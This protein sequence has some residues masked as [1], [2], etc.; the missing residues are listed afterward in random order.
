MIFSLPQR[1]LEIKWA[2]GGYAALKGENRH[3]LTAKRNRDLAIKHKKIMGE[4]PFSL[5][6]VK[7]A[8]FGRTLGAQYQGYKVTKYLRA[9]PQKRNS[10]AFSTPRVKAS[11]FKLAKRFLYTAR[12]HFFKHFSKRKLHSNKI[13]TFNKIWQKQFFRKFNKQLFPYISKIISKFKRSLRKPSH[14]TGNSHSLKKKF[15][16]FSSANPALLTFLKRFFG[17]ITF[18]FCLYLL[19]NRFC[20]VN[21]V[22]ITDPCFFVP[23]CSI[24]TFNV[25]PTNYIM[26][27][28]LGVRFGKKLLKN[29]FSKIKIKAYSAPTG[30]EV[31]YKSGEIF[32][33]N[34]AGTYGP[35]ASFFFTKQ[36]L[37]NLF[38]QW[39]FKKQRKFGLK[40][41]YG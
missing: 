1:K 8:L 12:K 5:Y 35:P 17:G 9:I 34:T 37:D 19:E 22:C 14:F 38:L 16:L 33:L 28:I 40:G 4:Y 7:T 29:S 3:D 26:L 20:N 18:S 11:A 21:G 32:F 6:P 41:K 36:N 25:M 10:P 24:L 30:C 23:S 15:F 31:N 13:L 27:L 39:V 2:L